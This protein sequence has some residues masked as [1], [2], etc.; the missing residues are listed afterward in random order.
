MEYEGGQV[1]CEAGGY[2][3]GRPAGMR[4]CGLSGW[5]SSV[6]RYCMLLCQQVCCSVSR[7]GGTGTKPESSKE[8]PSP[9]C[10]QRSALGPVC[11]ERA[12]SSEQRVQVGR[13]PG[14][15]IFMDMVVF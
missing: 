1:W 3:G 14:G 4:V 5:R 6:S 7:C 2:A 12:A 13:Q 8:I 15:S 9:S 10:L 11:L